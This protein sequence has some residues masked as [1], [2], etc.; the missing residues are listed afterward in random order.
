MVSV[1]I[2]HQNLTAGNCFEPHT[3]FTVFSYE[4]FHMKS[5]LDT[6]VKG[7]GAGSGHLNICFCRSKKF[8]F[9]TGNLNVT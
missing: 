7:S 3:G 4:W 5:H 9:A 1:L 8:F 2:S 6:E